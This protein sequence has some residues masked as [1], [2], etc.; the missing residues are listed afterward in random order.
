MNEGVKCLM[1]LQPD[2][3]QKSFY[4]KAQVI[5]AGRTQELYSYGTLV[6]RITG[7]LVELFPKWS[8]SLT[9][10]KHLT[11]F[12]RQNGFSVRTKRDIEKL[13]SRKVFECS[14]D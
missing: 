2:D 12:L 1:E 5:K 9:T 13:L 10:T 3:S 6:C 8:Y 11:S 4:G 14:G 7:N